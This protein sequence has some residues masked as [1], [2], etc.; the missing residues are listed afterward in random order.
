[1]KKWM[2]GVALFGCGLTA[3]AMGEDPDPLLK[4]ACLIGIAAVGATLYATYKGWVI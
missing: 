1:M 4:I 3:S 2:T